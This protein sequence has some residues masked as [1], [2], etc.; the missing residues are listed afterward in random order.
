MLHPDLRQ[1]LGKD[2]VAALAKTAEER[3]HTTP[4]T[5]ANQERRR[6]LR[7]PRLEPRTSTAPD[8]TTT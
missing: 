3:C 4:E 7:K 6:Q 2:N 1:Q 8:A 5:T